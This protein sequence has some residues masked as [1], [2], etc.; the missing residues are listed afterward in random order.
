MGWR[1]NQSILKEINPEYS[2]K[3]TD[4]EAEAEAP[5]LWPPDTKSQLIGKYTDAG[6]D[7]R[8]R[9]GRDRGWNGWM[10]SMTQWTW[11]WENSRRWWRTGKPGMLQ[12]TVSQ[13][14][15]QLSNWTTNGFLSSQTWVNTASISMG[16]LLKMWLFSKT[17]FKRSAFSYPH[18]SLLWK[19]FSTSEYK[20]V[21]SSL[22][23]LKDTVFKTTEKMMCFPYK[24]LSYSN[25]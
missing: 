21:W 22:T 3:K 2:L 17:I 1:S 13:S 24:M 14:Q 7:L 20:S 4:A 12:S 8:I 19:M 25:M 18:F 23:C 6:K 10:V 15:T 16:I 5:I 9:E 11:V